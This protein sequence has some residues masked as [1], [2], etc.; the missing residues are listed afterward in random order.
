MEVESMSEPSVKGTM[1][2][3]SV[4]LARRLKQR[5]DLRTEI[6][7]KSLSDETLS[8]LDDRIIITSWYPMWQFN[9]LQE[10]FWEHVARRDPRAARASGADSFKSMNKTG[11]YQQFEYAARAESAESKRDVLRHTRMITSILSGYY[12]FLE[13]K[14]GLDPQ[15]QNL[16]I[17]YDNA[18][19][20]CEPLRYSTEGFMTAVSRVRNGV[21]DWTSERV[22]PDRIVYTLPN[23][24]A[25]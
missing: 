8:L 21:T 9:E 18:T 4:V 2:L 5:G 20:Y 11:R 16:Q 25:K 1:L 7:E 6:F 22:T 12:N 17:V 19:M 24:R 13:V 10:F 3:G 23:A 15:S 14:V